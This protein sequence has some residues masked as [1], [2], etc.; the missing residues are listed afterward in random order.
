MSCKVFD[1]V[2]EADDGLEL[3]VG[4]GEGGL[5]LGV[6]VD[7]ALDLIQSVNNEHI[8]Q[9]LAGSVQP[10]VEGLKTESAF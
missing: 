9:V 7:Q 6:G 10:V 8:D 3:L 2:N 5:E 1:L 4:L